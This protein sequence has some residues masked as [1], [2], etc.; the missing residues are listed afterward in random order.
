[1][2]K[3]PASDSGI[4]GKLYAVLRGYMSRYR[5]S[6]SKCVALDPIETLLLVLGDSIE[7]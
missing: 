2:R 3:G 1:M 6:I 5:Y 7:T 4:A